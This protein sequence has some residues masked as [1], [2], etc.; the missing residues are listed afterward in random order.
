MKLLKTLLALLS[1]IHLLLLNSGIWIVCHG[2]SV[3]A[4]SNNPQSPYQTLGVDRKCSQEELRKSYKSLCLKYHPDK[5][6]NKSSRERQSAET[7]FKEIQAAYDMLGDENKRRTY[8][9]QEAFGVHPSDPYGAQN[10]GFSR[11]PRRSYGAGSDPFADAFAQAFRANGSSFRVFRPNPSSVFV[12][13]MM[14]SGLDFK[15]IYHTDVEISLEKLYEGK[16]CDFKVADNMWTRWRA[17][18]RGKSLYL[19]LYQGFIY[20]L[21]VMRASKAAAFIVWLSI[22]HVTLPKTDPE[23]TYS[24]KLRPGFKG[25]SS[26]TFA[27][28]GFDSPEIVFRVKEERNKLYKRVGNDL[29]T[30]IEITEKEASRGCKKRVKP[31]SSTHEDKAGKLTVEIPPSVEDGHLLRLNGKGWPIKN[32]PGVYLYGDLVVRVKIVKKRRRQKK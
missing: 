17:A 29:H 5:N 12:D 21:P 26:I 28:T 27:S 19:C 25:D 16:E 10:G 11:D 9:M 22:V 14:E 7:K 30:T 18:I 32:A 6:V 1:S 15:S 24:H 4:R 31:L 23:K 20:A 8:E 13:K 2:P 3:T